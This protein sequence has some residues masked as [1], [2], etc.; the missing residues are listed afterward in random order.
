MTVVLEHNRGLVRDMPRLSISLNIAA[1]PLSFLYGTTAIYVA[2]GLLP[3]LILDFSREFYKTN[4]GIKTFAN[5]ITHTRAST[6]TYVDS[7][8]TLQTA[9]IN[10]PR[11]GH[12]V[13]NGSAWVNEGLLHESEARTNGIRRICRM[14]WVNETKR[15]GVVADEVDVATFQVSFEA[16][17]LGPLES[18]L[19]KRQ[20]HL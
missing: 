16:G 6:A 14:R 3:E 10:E 5:T 9:A 17:I 12:H 15:A 7:T 20:G 19:T 8:G 13:W 4:A 2:S 18:F 1:N 11:V